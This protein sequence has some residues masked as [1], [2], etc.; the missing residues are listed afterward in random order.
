MSILKSFQPSR[1]PHMF[2]NLCM[3]WQVIPPPF[4]YHVSI[5]NIR[6]FV[7]NVFRLLSAS[8]VSPVV[9]GLYPSSGLVCSCWNRPAYQKGHVFLWCGP[10]GRYQGRRADLS[11]PARTPL[12]W[13][14]LS[15]S[16]EAWME[17]REGVRYS[18]C[19]KTQGIWCPTEFPGSV[20]IA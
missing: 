7:C 10:S 11:P 6:V 14:A 3:C 18:L 1:V 19:V 13:P 2:L 16:V 12:R 17:M 9:K 15:G 4:L 5:V 20:N 8:S